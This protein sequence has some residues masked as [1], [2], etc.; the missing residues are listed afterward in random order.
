MKVFEDEPLEDAA[1]D[2]DTAGR[3]VAGLALLGAL[4]IAGVAIYYGRRKDTGNPA[5]ARAVNETYQPFAELPPPRTDAFGK[6]WRRAEK[7]ERVV[8]DPVLAERIARA[9]TPGVEAAYYA[10]MARSANAH[11]ENRP[12]AERNIRE[13]KVWIPRAERLL[14]TLPS[15]GAIPKAKEV[16]APGKGIDN[17]TDFLNRGK[18][19][20]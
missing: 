20:T 1:G 8:R 11:N 2:E 15:A 12:E 6:A 3:G 14:D 18:R 10:R 9:L 7:I 4:A 13:V 17:V 5:V 19:R 16:L